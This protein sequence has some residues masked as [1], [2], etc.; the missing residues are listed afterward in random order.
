MT[1]SPEVA[2][3]SL[4]SGPKIQPRRSRLSPPWNS[5]STHQALPKASAMPVEVADDIQNFKP[6]FEYIAQRQPD[7]QM[8]ETPNDASVLF[9]E[10]GWG[11]SFARFQKGAI[12][13]QDGR[14]D[15]YQHGL[16]SV[17]VPLLTAALMEHFSR[18]EAAWTI[19]HLL[20]GNNVLGDV[21]IRALS[22]FLHDCPGARQH[23]MT[24]YIPANNVTSQGLADMA[25]ILQ[26]DALGIQ[27]LWFKRNPLG[28][29]SVP[30]LLALASSCPALRCLD[31]DV[32]EL[33][34]DGC[35][36]LCSGLQH[37]NTKLCTLY[38]SG[39]GAGRK[40]CF[41]LRN[42]CASPASPESLYLTC[43]PIGDEGIAILC[44]GFARNTNLRRLVLGSTG[45]SSA[46]VSALCKTIADHP[47][48]LHLD[49]SR[50]PGTGDLEAHSNHISKEAL[51][52]IAS[53]IERAESLR[54]IVLG[55]LEIDKQ[56]LEQLRGA[57]LIRDFPKRRIT[58]FSASL[59][60]DEADREARTSVRARRDRFQAALSQAGQ[61][62]VV[63]E[64]GAEWLGNPKGLDVVAHDF[65]RF[66]C[67]TPS[68]R[69]YELTKRLLAN[70]REVRNADSIFKAEVLRSR[71]KRQP[72]RGKR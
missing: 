41:A 64:G 53:L 7:Q 59:P 21:G 51:T 46:G 30:A 39:N 72:L 20:L 27:S 23:L 31:V 36:A 17:H 34:D 54:S 5:C 13:L 56:D 57:V 22:S 42:L 25:S 4:G 49:L 69:L 37:S 2:P 26:T 71:K 24:L 66:E 33:G 29:T 48:L 19:R 60:S 32:C 67:K 50:A 62:A 63:Q 55:R 28:P 8:D 6:L 10:K 9:A 47:T 15:L 18:P 38:L 44:D 1:P 3:A 45:M 35:A 14:L 12:C 43:S 58:V 61:Q 40:T 70:P 68:D 65:L 16:S 52:P 11:A